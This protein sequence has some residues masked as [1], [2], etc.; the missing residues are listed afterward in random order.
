ME[1]YFVRHGESTQN[2]ALDEFMTTNIV[3][4]ERGV[5]QVTMTGKY[6]KK[7]GKFDAIYSSPVKR[8]V[9]TAEIIA[10]TMNY[11]D[12]IIETDL[13]LECGETHHKFT[14]IPESERS[15]IMDKNKKIKKL[16]N[17]MAKEK[18]LMKQ[19]KLN[20]K[21]EKELI[22]YLEIKPTKDEVLENYQT[23]LDM[24]KN[25]DIQ[26]ILCI[27]HGGTIQY[28]IKICTGVNIYNNLVKFVPFYSQNQSR[29]PN[30][31][32]S[33]F[34]LESDKFILVIPPTDN[35][36]IKQITI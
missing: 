15:R 17:K 21:Y 22:N 5:E 10:K 12:Q 32:I 2:V 18:N 36:L 27:A 14:G 25:Q 30:C 31:S 8:C 24:V 7:Y 11:N 16:E 28:M 26:R 6:L 20:I 1:L 23:F 34:L 29:P 4:T 13:L 9:E 3:L 35:H 19:F 33:G